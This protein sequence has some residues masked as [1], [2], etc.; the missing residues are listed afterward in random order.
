MVNP[1]GFETL[2][3]TV[4][5]HPADTVSVPVAGVLDRRSTVAWHGK[6]EVRV[7]TVSDPKP[8]HDRGLDE[9]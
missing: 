8:P 9:R 5:A 6:R 4:D 2:C 3:A 1:P 7:N